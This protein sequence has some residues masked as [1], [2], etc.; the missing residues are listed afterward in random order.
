MNSQQFK[1]IDE[2]VALFPKDVQEILQKVRETIHQTV[3][4]AQEVISY[5][6]PAFKKDKV[7]VYFAAQKG[8]LGFYPTA[9]PI[10]KFKKELAS[11]QTTKGAIHFPFN[12]PIPYDL[13]EKIT[14]F[15]A[16][17]A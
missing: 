7:L 3:P 8:Y 15:R 11:Y 10:E 5:S 12:Q 2:Y 6:M 9:S 1:N 13:I 4:D 16:E 14:R 17:I